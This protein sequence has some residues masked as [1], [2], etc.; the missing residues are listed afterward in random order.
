MKVL[1]IGGVAGGAST[2]ARLRRLDESARIIMFEKGE[3][4]SF[5]NCGLPY[6]VGDVI[7]DR[8]N[9]LVMP[10]ATMTAR[11]NID[12]RTM[13][14]VTA[15]DR[16]AKTVTVLDRRSGESYTESYDKLVIATGSSPVVPGFV[17][18]SSPRIY[19]VWNM[20]DADSIKTRLGLGRPRHATVIGGGFVG[21]EM[22]ENLADLGIPTALVELQSQV[23]T[24][25]DFDM[26]QVLHKHIR[27]K[28]V[29]LRLSTGLDSYTED[30]DGLHL[31]LS[32]GSTLDTDLMILAVGVRP[33]SGLAK[34]AGL[35][36]NA[37]GGI[38][39]D[40]HML[41]SDPDIYAV[42]DVVE[43]EHFVTG[44]RTMIPL[45]GP[46]NKQGRV[47]ADNL[48]G[49]PNVYRGS[50]GASVAKVF[51][52]TAASV[53]LNMKQ[54]SAMGMEPGRDYCIAKAH[55]ASNATYYPD[56]YQLNLKVLYTREGKILGAMA[57]GQKMA[58]K[59]IDVIA[60]AMH[61][62]AH[63]TTLKDLEL[64][65]APPYSSAKD[66]VN[67]IG[68]MAEN[69]LNG[70]SPVISH[71]EYAALSEAEKAGYTLL[72]VRE[73]RETQ[74]GT[75]PGAVC[76]PL[77]Q[78]RARHEELD[79]SRPVIVYCAVGVRAH[80]ATRILRGHGFDAI[81]LSGGYTTYSQLQD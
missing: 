4:I 25:V 81:N 49:I 51:D 74:R 43:T 61:Y 16:G 47:C 27:K 3:Y 62:G 12:I 69:N 65:Y 22:M 17:D 42:G 38:V 72:D 18:I 6:F 40:E 13:S 10:Q 36:L 8:G 46:A 28:G 26:A 35:E 48:A 33:N 59:R 29:D 55:G 1:I 24:N 76:I 30:E 45:A 7:T 15:I 2:A 78:L 19:N 80:T 60:T 23:M 39:T 67:M 50:K 21:M 56:S 9:L 68:F 71:E 79:K 63:V 34:A 11:F 53:G 73:P 58:E 32:D 52:L 66:P 14:E 75:M 31:T 41:T 37:K 64:C 44:Q 54:L 5:A 57:V 20:T 77:G 70:I